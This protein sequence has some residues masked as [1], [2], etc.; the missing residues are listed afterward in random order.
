MKKDVRC[1]PIRLMWAKLRD[2]NPELTPYGDRWHMSKYLD[3]ASGTFIYTLLSGRCPVD[4]KPTSGNQ[5][6]LNHW[7]AQRVG[8]KPPGEWVG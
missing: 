6:A 2:L 3:T 1:I 5:D 4:D 8:T 7:L